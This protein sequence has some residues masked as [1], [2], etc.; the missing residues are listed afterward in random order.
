MKALAIALQIK[1]Y[2]LQEIHHFKVFLS[3][4]ER[5]LIKFNKYYIRHIYVLQL[6]Q[7]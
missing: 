7:L 3:N 6:R 5:S 4:E 1:P 2:N